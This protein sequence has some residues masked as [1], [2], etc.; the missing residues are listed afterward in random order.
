VRTPFFGPFAVS[1]STNLA[2]NQLINLYPELVEG[3]QGKEVGALYG[4]PGIT[5]VNKAGNGPIRGMR[6]VGGLLYVVSGNQLYSF[7]A[8]LTSP[9]LI[10]T[11]DNYTGPVTMIDTGAGQQLGI[12]SQSLFVLN[13]AT[14][15]LAQV[16]LPFT[17]TPGVGAYMDGFGLAAQL[18]SNLLWQ[19]DLLD[20][21]SWNALDFG[22]ASGNA[23]PT[24][25]LAVVYRELFIIKQTVTEI[26]INAGNP[27]LAFQR[28]DG[29]Y[30]EVGTD[31]PASVVQ[32][33]DS[34]LW[35]G[36]NAMGTGFA[37]E[38]GGLRPRT[39][40]T[41]PISRVFQGYPKADAV[42]YS[43]QQEHHNFYVVNFPSGDATWV[44]DRTESAM[45][46]EPMWHRRAAFSNGAFHRH[47]GNVHAYFAGKHIIGDWQ[48][49]NL[50][51]FD[52]TALTDNGAPRKWLRSWRALQQPSEQPVRF[53]SLRIDMQTGIGVPD[54]ANPQVILRWS[55]DGGHNWSN[56]RFLSAGKTGET[57]RRVKANRMGSTRRN[58]GLD[59]IFELSSTDPFPVALMGA[60]LE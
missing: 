50:Y 12:F 9:T 25:A 37:V 55:D 27:G 32:S 16:S 19:S 39:I 48:N 5:L 41:H 60:E 49:G 11:L 33:D 57:T 54:G 56:E 59:R 2:D 23:E 58:H 21:T 30:I 52:L 26:W 51:A 45:A 6:I 28:L 43:Y 15:S 34:L 10:G 3:R 17:P 4:T 40:S 24:V 13:L 46:K 22:S 18:Q 47:P 7:D 31:A 14:H 44:Y 35:L 38:V 20:L 29:V 1:R 8:S 36:R 42:A 53:T